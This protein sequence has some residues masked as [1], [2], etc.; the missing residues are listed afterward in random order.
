MPRLQ[1]RVRCLS[2]GEALDDELE[3]SRL[4]ELIVGAVARGGAPVVA[5]VV[6]AERVEII[7]LEPLQQAGIAVPMFLAG[8]SRS[9][10][11]GAGAAE[12]VGLMG[13]VSVSQ[14]PAGQPPSGAPPAPMAIAFL[15]WSDCRWWSWRAAVDR[16]AG[17]VLEDTQV[18]TRA[19]DGDP[20]PQ[21]LGRWWSLG[22][23]VGARVRLGPVEQQPPA[24]EASNLVH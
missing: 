23:R 9:E 12:A 6:R 17:A 3:G 21:G 13:V 4:R 5:V 10:A 11:E 19:A 7:G 18:L 1:L 2:R 20:L 22:R 15:E 14:A 16:A 24:A 8:L